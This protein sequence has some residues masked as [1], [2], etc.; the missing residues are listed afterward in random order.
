MLK[1]LMRKIIYCYVLVM[2][3]TRHTIV[4]ISQ[5]I[6][7][8][9]QFVLHLKLMLYI[10]FISVKKVALLYWVVVRIKFQW[11]A[12]AASCRFCSSVWNIPPLPF[13]SQRSILGLSFFQCLRDPY[14]F[15]LSHHLSFISS[16]SSLV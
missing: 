1:V 16:C 7:I 12:F 15:S 9:N 3:L 11:S 2:M 5:Y 13:A 6:F 10:S 14:S 4:I 8:W